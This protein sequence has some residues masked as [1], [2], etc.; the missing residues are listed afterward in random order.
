VLEEAEMKEFLSGELPRRLGV[1]L[2]RKQQ[3]QWRRQAA[4]IENDKETIVQQSQ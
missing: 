4:A 1:R 3:R 2:N